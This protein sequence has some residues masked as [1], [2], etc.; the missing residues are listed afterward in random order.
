MEEESYVR[1]AVAAVEASW[2]VAVLVALQLSSSST[3]IL[4][5]FFLG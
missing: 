2:L 1:R 4:C 3:A 5:V